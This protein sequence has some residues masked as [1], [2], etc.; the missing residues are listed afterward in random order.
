MQKTYQSSPSSCSRKK[1]P[2]TQQEPVVDL[3]ISRLAT[4]ENPQGDIPR[5][6][7]LVRP[8]PLNRSHDQL[9]VDQVPLSREAWNY[10]E[11]DRVLHWLDARGGGQ[12]HLAHR[13]RG[14]VGV[15]GG[16]DRP[17]SVNGSARAQFL[18]SVAKD[19]GASYQTSAGKVVGLLWDTNS[20]EWK[21]ADWVNNRLL[22]TY[23]VTQES[24][25]MPPS[26]TFEFEDKET[27]D[28][29]W[30]PALGA[31]E[32]SLKLGTSPLGQMIWNLV[33]KS[34]VAPPPDYGTASGPDSV[35]PYWLQAV[36]DGAAASINGVLEIDGLAPKGVLIGMQ[37]TR[38][39]PAVAGYYQTA[40]DKAP[41]A[42]FHGALHADGKP[43]GRCSATSDT[44][45][46]SG[47]SALHQQ[48]FGLPESGSLT[49]AAHGMQGKSKQQGISATR[50]NTNATL[51]LLANH[52]DVHPQVRSACQAHVTA[53]GDTSLTM[54][55]LLAMTPFGKD[56]Q[57]NWQDVVQQSVRNDLGQI[58]NSFISD[59]I[60]A[61]LFPNTPKPTLSPELVQVAHTAVTGVADPT[62]WYQSLGTAVMTQGMANGSDQYC[63]NM[64][65]P[66]AG[67]WLQQEVANAPV[68]QAHSQLLFAYEWAARFPQIND[69]LSDQ[70]VNS[71]LYQ[72]TIDSQVQLSVN[73][74]ETNVAVNGASPPN[75]KQD[76][77]NEVR[78]AGM[79]AKTNKLY[80]AFAYY[81]WNT[82]PA[83]LANIAIQM[84]I[85]TG[86]ADGTTLSRLFQQNI[87][88]L[89]ALDPSGYF[90]QKYNQTINTFMGANILPSMYGFTGDADDFNLFKQ[91]LQQFVSQNINSET[92]QIAQAAAQI[93]AI[94]NEQDADEILKNSIAALRTISESIQE[95]M[96]LPYV[97]NNF[98]KWFETSYP[99]L[100]KY[101]K[102]FGTLVVGGLSM[103][104]VFNMVREYKEWDKLSDGEKAELVMETC[105]FGLQLISAV[106]V[107]GVRVYAIYSAEGLTTGQRVAGIFKVL[108]S[109]EAE[110]SLMND[111]MMDVSSNMARWLGDTAGSYAE[112]E[113]FTTMARAGLFGEEEAA[114]V[115]WTV[116]VFG[117][118]LDEFIA[119]RV[120]PLLILAGMGLSIYFIATG[121]SGLAL[122]ADIC[123]L[124]SGAFA[125]FAIVGG[126]FVG[127]ATAGALATLVSIAGP[128]AIIAA[129]VGIGLMIYEMFQT[130]PDPVK[131]FLD[132][133]VKPAGFFVASQCGAIDYA[134]S[135]AAAG[136]HLLMMGFQL[137]LRGQ[138]VLAN[139]DGSITFGSA[140]NLPS[141]VWASAVDGFGQCQFAAQVQRE[142]GKSPIN[143]LLSLMSDNTISFQPKTP[144]DSQPP[145]GG[146]GPVVRTQTWLTDTTGNVNTVTTDTGATALG[147][148]SMIIRP[149][150]P[151]AKGNY[152]PAQAS[153][154]LLAQGGTL[155]W[156]ASDGSAF[157]L[158]MAGL[159]PFYMQ[160]VDPSFIVNTT[161]STAE[162]YGPSFGTYPSS[163]LQFTLTGTLPDFLKFDQSTGKLNPNGKGTG[164]VALSKALTL[165]CRNVLGSAQIGFTIKVS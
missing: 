32:A 122:G 143:L 38:A 19:C 51:H 67:A 139:S 91:Y 29:P 109:G 31:F 163:P 2:V 33:F 100:A 106:V 110:T 11:H 85:S 132:D 34:E 39:L 164:G 129:L 55:G 108:G 95:A 18:C 88:V 26:F 121:E 28:L 84:G 120:G 57:G 82:S 83:I 98:V 150:L 27:G 149:V 152:S 79:Y 159:A 23:T 59:S 73:D 64:N 40:S 17:V 89:T 37:G 81:T 5:H 113:A 20:P 147:S 142:E 54:Q 1:V 63:K 154:Y 104:A 49:F 21:Q 3:V 4:P 111:A 65:G 72:P 24:P 10:D 151:D 25:I 130:P 135:Y 162:T 86:S 115:S 105:Q 7:T 48:C 148:L 90:A 71:A 56:N 140:T 13:A 146:A 96:S 116:K 127:E 155:S 112:R 153:G 14:A 75:L 156:N 58:M 78:E 22:L 126:W 101:S 16:A 43:V 99:R 161:P 35:Y 6:I 77:E 47:L 36:E 119:T 124:V 44:L 74:I 158:N 102:A 123:N 53:L 68:Y 42:I 114:E 87:T 103:L 117:K 93:Q 128:L 15:I 62:A 141:C 45:T 46:W 160:M 137:I 80:W 133:Y 94:L 9:F 145:A 30:D 12:L 61:L 50:L 134:I 60:W 157:T 66:R 76:L 118:N 144:K 52:D 69:Y 97:A 131:Q 70:V 136:T 92:L 107:R 41:F 8:N 165:A 125:L 138:A